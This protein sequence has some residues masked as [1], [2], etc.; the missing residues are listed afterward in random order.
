MKSLEKEQDGTQE[1]P[2]PTLSLF[3]NSTVENLNWAR[4]GELQ[5][6]GVAAGEKEKREAVCHEWNS[7]L[8]I[9]LPSLSPKQRSPVQDV[10]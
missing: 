8:S 7:F 9:F 4:I 1:P 6:L 3:G 5:A 2:L 10:G